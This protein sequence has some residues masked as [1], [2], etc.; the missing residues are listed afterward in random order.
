MGRSRRKHSILGTADY[1]SDSSRRGY[2][3]RCSCGWESEFCATPSFAEA[4]GEQH[5]ELAHLVQPEP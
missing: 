4:S 5:V 1:R 2:S 3:V